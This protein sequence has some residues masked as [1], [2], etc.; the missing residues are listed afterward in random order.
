MINQ[1]TQHN[2]F[3]I[4]TSSRPH[5]S[6]E[7][8]IQLNRGVEGKPP[9]QDIL[10]SPTGFINDWTFIKKDVSEPDI[11]YIITARYKYQS[12]GETLFGYC[13]GKG[14]T[15]QR[16]EISAAGEAAERFS[17]C[18]YSKEELIY[19]SYHEVRE[20]ALDPRQLILYLPEQYPKLPFHPF[21]DDLELAWVNGRSLIHDKPVLIPAI[22]VFLD[23]PLRNKNEKI[24][25]M[26]SSGLAAGPTLLQAIIAGTLE[27]IERDAFMNTWYN[28][29]PCNRIDIRTHP[30]SSISELVA[31]YQERGVELQLLK[32]STDAPCHV[33]MAIAQQSAGSGPYY[34]VGL[35]SGF[36]STVAAAGAL[37]EL[38]QVRASSDNYYEHPVTRQRIKELVESPQLVDAINDH[39][40]LYAAR[41]PS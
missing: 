4:S 41:G 1:I 24:A 9:Y 5:F 11:P 16:A 2:S 15:H 29:L 8:L 6:L 38:A 34:A 39:R 25:E 3:P 14:I 28:R 22:A 20:I 12:E 31:Q 21:Q 10:R 13:S 19:A 33:F 18:S 37:L 7:Q 36:S 26:H 30:A 40:L 27:V 17:A 32:L 23:C 35:G